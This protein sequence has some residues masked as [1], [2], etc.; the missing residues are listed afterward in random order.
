MILFRS[1][2]SHLSIEYNRITIL[3]N[4]FLLSM[5]CEMTTSLE[6]PC[7]ARFDDT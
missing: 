1:T 3:K 7:S 4:M 5:F 6:A 2:I